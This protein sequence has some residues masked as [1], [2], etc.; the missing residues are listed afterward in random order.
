MHQ[1]LVGVGRPTAAAGSPLL[2]GLVSYWKLDEASGSAVD[3]HGSNTLTD[4]NT[5]G[6]ATGKVGNARLFVPANAECLSIA[7][8]ASLSMGAEQDWTLAA[9]VYFNGL[10]N[11]PIIAGKYAGLGNNREYAIWYYSD[12]SRLGVIVSPDGD[13]P[14]QAILNANSQGAISTAFWY[15]LVG[16]HDAT[17]NTLNV[18]VNGGTVDSMAYSLGIYDGTA[19]FV[20][21]ALGGDSQFF[22]G[23]ID[24]VG[25]W[26]RVLTSTER[27]QLWNSSL[28]RTYPFPGT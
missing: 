3:S 10:G 17:A 1:S 25:L 4:V 28:G 14:Q 6:T 26:K 5:V 15:L 12:Q 24:E 21:G 20:L 16:W 22:D 23:R 27:S 9:W 8:N 13:W 7:D 19:P 2:T 11:N 18:Q